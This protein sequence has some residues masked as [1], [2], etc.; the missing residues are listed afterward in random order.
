MTEA[1]RPPSGLAWR[2]GLARAVLWFEKVIP[3]AAPAA[4]PAALF[5][6]AALLDMPGRLPWWA[7]GALLALTAAAVLALAWRGF[8]RFAPPGSAAADRRLERDSGLAHRPLAA[9]SDRPAADDL[10][11][12]AVWRAH[13]ARGLA[14]VRTLRL[15]WPH[16]GLARLDRRAVRHALTL[17]LLASLV[18]AGPDAPGRLAAAFEPGLPRPAAPPPVEIQAWVTPPAYTG[19]PPL[20]LK[21]DRKTV[22]VPDGSHLTIN[23]TGG[24]TAPVL[25]LDSE[26][27]DFVPLDR[28]SFQADRTL[29]RSVSLSV[30]RTN[31]PLARWDV[32]V[33][34][35]RP[36]T[37]RWADPPGPAEDHA[38]IRLSWSAA[39]DY[40]VTGLMAELRLAGRPEAPPIQ[41]ALPLPAGVL[42]SAHGIH[43]QDLIAHPWAGLGVTAR[44][45]ARDGAGQTGASA[46]A[47]F[48]LPERIFQNP[49][50]KALI[51]IRKG[52]S[53][54]PDDHGDA[55]E[56]LDGLLL[57]PGQFGSDSTAFLNL[58]S[59]YYLLVRH[60]HE[61]VVPEA[62]ARMWD[63]ALHMEEGLTE[64]SARALDLARQAV[65]DSMDRLARDPSDA[66]RQDLERKL[67]ELREAIDRH[68][69]AMT[70]EAARNKEA[71]PFDPEAEQLT[72]QDLDRLADEARRAA[73][74]GR[75]DDAR[76][77]MAELERLLDRMKQ[78]RADRGQGNSEQRQKGRRQ[79]GAVQ[80]MVAR[81]GGLLDHTESR[82]EQANRPRRILPGPGEP[83]PAEA[84]PMDQRTQRALRNALGE[85]M[86]QFGDLTGEVPPA[87][88]EADRAMRDA[89]QSLAA[90]NDTAAAAAEQRAIEALQ[91]GAREM[92]RALARQFGA[93]RQ[94]G[95]QGEGD[96]F[97]A[98]GPAFRDGR[99]DGRAG[100]G[101]LPGAPRRADS[102][103]R[104]PLGRT[105]PGGSAENGEVTVPEAA[106]QQRAQ[107]IQEEL[108]RRGAE[109]GRP[110]QERA[111]IDRLLR[112]F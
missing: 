19:L 99:G 107:A 77:K 20:F 106:E 76:D 95:E 2:R 18:I 23:L 78:A 47:A 81:E 85:M 44:L 55:L 24:Q 56:V 63:L 100:Q 67:K 103:Q 69:R 1:P 80:D 5:A 13:V 86:Q 111:Y 105:N 83:D 73:E 22:S 110:Q 6:I 27:V 16:P 7:H 109:S 21:H 71:L 79:M 108:R 75:M 88:T 112:R 28:S 37:A 14:Q 93:G 45:V 12:Q 48:D 25:L 31:E 96:G 38:R 43:H 36:P 42:T 70:E 17:S 46:D 29:T 52:L 101:P 34:A 89:A 30:I 59:I 82:A 4:V 58:S 9:L 26:R 97:G 61:D 11:G 91:K 54:H 68:L 90:E 104:D 33:V 62:Q 57:Q 87:L 39:D 32:S 8:T 40:G 65:R 49:V 15:G 94:S 41:I 84:R 10:I 53:L 102:R 50:A 3:A 74:E 35:D 60:R 92:G 98:E 51:G 66:N 64:E 72:S